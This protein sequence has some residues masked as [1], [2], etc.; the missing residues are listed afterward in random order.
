MQGCT[1]WHPHVYVCARMQI[2]RPC[3]VHAARCML[4]GACC[5]V[6]AARCMLHVACCTLHAA[7]CMLHVACCT[8]H[9]ACCTLHAAYRTLHVVCVAAVALP[10]ACRQSAAWSP[11]PPSRAQACRT[12]HHQHDLSLV[13]MHCTAAIQNRNMRSTAHSA[14]GKR[15]QPFSSARTASLS[16]G[17]RGCARRC[18]GAYSPLPQV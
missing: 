17:G 6:H 9:V 12:Y 8:L 7:R 15:T 16:S 2:L 18:I 3:G 4:H 14:F 11:C 13:P 10:A 5:T 1:A